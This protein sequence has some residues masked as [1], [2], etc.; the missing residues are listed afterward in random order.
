MLCDQVCLKLSHIESSQA[1]LVRYEEF[2]AVWG[3]DIIF[4]KITTVVIYKI[5]S[6]TIEYWPCEPDRIKYS[7]S[8]EN[9]ILCIN[10]I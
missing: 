2:V 8:K 1:F 4:H 3:V 6:N 7:N 9:N 10:L 5:K